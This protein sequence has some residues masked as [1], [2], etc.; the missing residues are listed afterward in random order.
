[1]VC[2][3]QVYNVL[4]TLGISHVGIAGPPSFD[5]PVTMLLTHLDVQAL[6]W[7]LAETLGTHM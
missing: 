1:M 5:V 6:F 7:V 2:G 4:S 3:D